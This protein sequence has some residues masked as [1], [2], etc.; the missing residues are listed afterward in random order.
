MNIAKAAFT[1]GLVGWLY[2]GLPAFVSAR[3]AFIESSR[4]EIFQNRAD[5]VVRA[6]ERGHRARP[7]LRRPREA[8]ASASER[9]RCRELP[10]GARCGSPRVASCS[11]TRVFA[12][13]GTES[14]VG[15]LRACG[16]P[17][18]PCRAQVT[19]I[20]VSFKAAS[21]LEKAGNKVC[22]PVKSLITMSQKDFLLFSVL[23]GEF[24]VSNWDCT[25]FSNVS[26]F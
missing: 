17:G 18:Q 25:R 4:G 12:L 3:K 13:L 15:C 24:V 11:G 23:T 21:F 5:A 7:G 10:L 19:Q 20:E 22:P 2:G 14:L 16:R 26:H 6:G 8:S 1:A 9:S